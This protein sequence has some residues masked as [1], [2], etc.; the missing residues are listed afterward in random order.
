MALMTAYHTLSL[1]ED[2]PQHELSAAF[3]QAVDA[4]WQLRVYTPGE[5]PILLP[6]WSNRSI[7]ISVARVEVI[8]GKAIVLTN[9]FFMHYLPSRH[10]GAAEM[11]FGP[12][13]LQKILGCFTMKKCWHEDTT[14][15]N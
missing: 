3:Q 1:S 14:A 11:L 15:C 4:G 5:P 8:D 7:G 13:P 6:P 12:R 10:M 9:E 2:S